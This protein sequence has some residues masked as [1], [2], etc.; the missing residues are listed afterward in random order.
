M[1]AETKGAPTSFTVAAIWDGE[2][3]VFYSQS[4]IPGLHVEAASFDEFV[5]LVREL[6]P[7]MIADNLPAATGPF[8][9]RV[10]GRR[11]LVVNAA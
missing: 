11:D 7:E 4:D 3:G 1:S 6:A 9:I 2:A 5:A 8:A 10:E